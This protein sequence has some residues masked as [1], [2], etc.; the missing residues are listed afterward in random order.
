MEVFKKPPPK[1]PLSMVVPLFVQGK[2]CGETRVDFTGDSGELALPGTLVLSCLSDIVKPE[3]VRDLREKVD[4]GGRLSRRTIEE[5]GLTVAFD[6]RRIFLSILV[7]DD[8]QGTQVHRLTG[9]RIDPASVDALPPNPFS[10]FVNMNAKQRWFY[11]QE[12]ALT[13]DHRGPLAVDFDSAWNWHGVVLEGSAAYLE[14]TEHPLQ[15]RDVRVVY[16]SPHD[17]LRYSAGDLQF[18]VVGYQTTVTMGGLGVSKDFSLQPYINAYPVSQFEFYLDTPATVDVWV[19]ETLTGTLRLPPG[20][21]DIRDFPFSSGQ[22]DVRIVITDIYGRTQDLRFSFIQ[23]TSLLAPGFSQFS[24]NAGLL[25][26]MEDDSYSYAS[27]EPVVSLFYQRGCSDVFTIGGYVQGLHDQGL[28]GI[29]GVYALPAGI[30]NFDTA[31]SAVRDEDWGPAGKLT[32]THRPK[33]GRSG[34]GISWQLE[35]E[36]LGKGF[37]TITDPTPDEHAFLNLSSYVVVPVG[38]GFSSSVG[39]GY[40]FVWGPDASNYYKLSGGLSRLWLNTVSSNLTVQGIRDIEGNN[41][42]SVFFGLVWMFPDQNQSVSLSMASGGSHDMQWDYNQPSS[43]PEKVYAHVSANRS[44]SQEHYQ[45][46]A[47]Y[48]GNCGTVELSQDLLDPEGHDDTGIVNQSAVTLGSSLVYVDGNWALSRPVSQGFVMVKGI[49]NLEGSQL[50]INPSPEGYQALSSRYSPA[51]LPSLSPYNIKKVVVE[52]VDPPTGYLVEKPYFTLFPTYKSGYALYVGSDSMVVVIGNLIDGGR[53][54]PF[55][56]QTIE[57]F[58]LDDEKAP[59]LRTFTNRKG[60]FQLL[61]LKPGNYE[62]RPDEASG[63]GAVTFQIPEG[64]EGIFKT[65]T[66]TLTG[67]P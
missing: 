63:L 50:A 57:V 4:S 44:S 6:A 59:P 8:L 17:L 31:L 38:R 12:S 16:D 28:A 15:R 43:V 54:E 36:Y 61:G 20:T 25:R 14:S 29:D 24:Y 45:A 34:T 2:P 47:G 41:S 1:L 46:K 35:A 37:S 22:N 26:T 7:P 62:I 3:I 5:A 23:E 52:P 48:I 51:V 19:N 65:G 39:I 49:K 10:G 11:P 13:H 32:F 18:P 56:H 33:P 42:T 55:G 53:G 66:M 9:I 60:Q 30:I 67:K 21:H 58:C 40:S 64:T 27:D